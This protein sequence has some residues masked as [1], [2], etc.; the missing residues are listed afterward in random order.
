MNALYN[1]IGRILTGFIQLFSMPML[2]N[3]L[4]TYN[5]GVFAS[6]SVVF[7]A[8]QI[9]DFGVGKSVIRL[10]ANNK[11][12][13]SVTFSALL[14]MTIVICVTLLILSQL[15]WS[16]PFIEQ[17]LDRIYQIAFIWGLLDIFRLLFIGKILYIK[18][19]LL[20]NVV[21][22]SVEIIKLLGIIFCG[23]YFSLIDFIIMFM[24][25]SLLQTVIYLTVVFKQLTLKV[26]EFSLYFKVIKSNK[27]VFMEFSFAN[28]VLKSTFLVDKIMIW[29]A[30]TPEVFAI[31]H[32]AMQIF[33]KAGEIPQNIMIGFNT[34]I[35]RNF[36]DENAIK[37]RRNIFD[38]IMY[39]LLFSFSAIIVIS[40]LG[41]QIIDLVIKERSEDIYGYI[42]LLMLSLPFVVITMQIQNI[43]T[44]A[45]KVSSIYYIQLINLVVFIVGIFLFGDTS[46]MVSFVYIAI[47]TNVVVSIMAVRFLRN[48]NKKIYSKFLIY[49][50]LCAVLSLMFLYWI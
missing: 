30:G 27:S 31:Y 13:S 40:F 48:F 36:N 17:R 14:L 42:N 2:F 46:V 9:F 22:V 20:F 28:L 11:V 45:G 6:L 34:D 8:T 41:N 33:S 10:M 39:S 12:P 1:V 7:V 47:V 16:L 35:A 38:S 50:I 43:M 44:V 23:E 29:L 5:Y 15:F 26:S 21:N 24:S 19:F 4:G 49:L 25:L 18:K 32:M 37:L 3:V